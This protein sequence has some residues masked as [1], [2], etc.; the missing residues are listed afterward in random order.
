MGW[1]PTKSAV[2]EIVHPYFDIRDKL[3]VQ[4]DL[5]FKGAELVIPVPLRKKNAEYGSCF[6]HRRGGLHQ[7][8]PRNHVLAPHIHRDEGVHRKM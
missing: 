4:G 8:S 3:I 6:T 7:E 2:P 1:P 5:V